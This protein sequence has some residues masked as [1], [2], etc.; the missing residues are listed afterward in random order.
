VLSVTIGAS[1][2]NQPKYL[3]LR[4]FFALIA[5]Y[6][7]ILTSLYTSKLI[8]VFTNPNYDYQINTVEELLN[9]EIPIGGRLENKDWFENDDPIDLEVFERYNTSKE[10]RPSPEAL[11]RII[12]ERNLGLLMSQL[13]VEQTDY[14]DDIFGITKEQF[15]NQLE[16]L[17]ERGFPL[18]RRINKI[19]GV[20]RDAGIASK[21]FEDFHYNSTILRSIREVREELIDAG[22]LNLPRSE[23]FDENKKKTEH[24]QGHEIVL[25][26]EHLQGP[27]TLLIVGLIISCVVFAM[28]L[29]TKMAIFQR[30]FVK[31][32]IFWKDF[33][34]KHFGSCFKV[35]NKMKRRKRKIFRLKR[36]PD[37]RFTPKHRR[38]VN[39]DD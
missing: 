16:M 8:D 29:L 5:L 36:R 24:T 15:S 6:S 31:F 32:K 34:K 28:E 33:K 4:F 39:F 35:L 38:K 25:T 9:T 30:N 26:L 13:Y 18:L 7:L 3:T 22:L 21:L 27:F 11:K 37:L 23:D 10:F 14:H 2:N 1:A 20:F 12:K 17:C 19:L